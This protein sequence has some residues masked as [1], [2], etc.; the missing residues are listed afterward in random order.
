MP[1]T[2]ELAL[3]VAPGEQDRGD[4]VL[5]RRGPDGASE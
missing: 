4:F 5:L 3:V 2:S 1:D